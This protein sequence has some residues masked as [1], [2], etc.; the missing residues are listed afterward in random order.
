[1]SNLPLPKTRKEKTEF[2]KA[3]AKEYIDENKNGIKSLCEICTPYT[4]KTS[5]VPDR[6]TIWKHVRKLREEDNH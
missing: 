6:R 2:Y 4:Q 5:F 3:I 1:M